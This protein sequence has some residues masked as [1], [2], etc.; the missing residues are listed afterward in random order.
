VLSLLSLSDLFV[1]PSVI[2]ACSLIMLEAAITKNLVVLNDD[3][4]SLHEFGG[5]R[6]EPF[7]S[8]RALYFSF[9]SVTRPITQY[10]P[11]EADWFV[12][13]ARLLVEIQEQDR[14][15]QFFKHVRKRHNPRW[16][17][18]QQLEPLLRQAGGPKPAKADV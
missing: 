2:E 12:D 13:H 4:E 17:Y 10:L 11:S 1:L 8:K 7:A 15:L 16:I 3:L 6:I 14:S 5:A 9:G 18:R